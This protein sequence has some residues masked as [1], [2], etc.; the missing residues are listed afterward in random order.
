MFVAPFFIPF[1][2]LNLLLIFV[3]DQ[4]SLLELHIQ[5]FSVFW[6][7][8]EWGGYSQLC[9]LSDRIIANLIDFQCYFCMILVSP[10]V[11]VL[12]LNTCTRRKSVIWLIVVGFIV[13]FVVFCC[14]C[15]YAVFCVS[16]DVVMFF[17]GAAILSHVRLINIILSLLYFSTSLFYMLSSSFIIPF[18]V[19]IFR[20]LF[21]SF[22][23]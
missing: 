19:A 23:Q 10:R 22:L 8:K 18:V 2:K 13:V 21:C 14:C 16:I 3:V 6:H 4:T 11:V 12:S 5:F 17:S 7:S 20:Y 15:F 1:Q 9:S